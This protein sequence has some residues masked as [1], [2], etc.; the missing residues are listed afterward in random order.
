MFLTTPDASTTLSSKETER[1]MLAFAYALSVE[2][3]VLVATISSEGTAADSEEPFRRVSLAS[4]ADVQDAIAHHA[5]DVVALHEDFPML[6]HLAS[7][8]LLYLSEPPTIAASSALSLASEILAPSPLMAQ[9]LADRSLRSDITS[10]PPP[11]VVLITAAQPN[12]RSTLLV[13]DGDEESEVIDA[14]TLLRR[15]HVETSLTI[16]MPKNKKTQALR[17]FAT[18]TPGVSVSEPPSTLSDWSNLFS[19]HEVLLVPALGASCPV[20]SV[21]QQVSLGKQVVGYAHPGLSHLDPSLASLVSPGDLRALALALD[22]ALNSK[23]DSVQN[24]TAIAFD[25]ARLYEDLLVKVCR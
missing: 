25:P 12:H 13:T 17:D 2:H 1:T 16:V 20:W 11:G 14:C 9:A 23:A 7:A 22:E 4:P 18:A 19:T 5:I 6:A 3:D 10:V 21:A 15:H 8:A 24:P